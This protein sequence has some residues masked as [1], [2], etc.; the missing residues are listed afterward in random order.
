[1][2]YTSK[3]SWSIFVHSDHNTTA[4]SDNK[5]TVLCSSSKC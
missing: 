5:G 2:F 1:M 3:Y 4:H